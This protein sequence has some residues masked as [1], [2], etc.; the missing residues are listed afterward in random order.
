LKIIMTQN[1]CQEKNAI[2]D[3]II[4]YIFP[5]RTYATSFFI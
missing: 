2:N 4:F 1:G 3:K 5:T